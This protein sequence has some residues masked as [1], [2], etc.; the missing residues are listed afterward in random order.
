MAK[1]IAQIQSFNAG[2]DPVRLALKY[3]RMRS[4]AFV[5]LRGSCHLF[6]AALPHEG[7]LAKAP[8][9]W[10]CGD[11][12]LENFGSYKGDNR[13]SYFDLNDFDEAVLAPVSWDLVRLLS[14][15]LVAGPSLHLKAAQAQQLARHG[16]STYTAALAQ[17]HSRWVERATAQGLVGDLLHALGDRKRA[18]FL[19]TRTQGPAAHRRLI[20]DQRKTWPVTDKQ[21]ERVTQLVRKATAPSL[22]PDRAD[23]FKVLDVVGR[24]AGTG[25]LGLARYAVLVQGKG[26]PDGHYLLDLKQSIPS[27]LLPRLKVPQPDWP[28]EGHR[29]VTLQ[30]RM[31]AVSPAFLHAIKDGKRAWQLRALQPTDDRVNLGDKALSLADLA[32]VIEVMAQT[33]AWAHLRSSGRQGSANADELI[34]LAQRPKWPG[35]LIEAAHGM[36]DRVQRDWLTYAQAFDDGALA[37]A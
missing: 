14:S 28:S 1:L 33:T 4:S 16:L 27:S 12:H 35:A 5:F 17:G 29:V 2:R 32:G 20:I 8:L 26:G 19:A 3:Q 9:A 36:A 7:V 34:D 11:L 18:D 13:L 22:D 31:Q 37:L 15:I 23:F 21:R 25:S 24:A 10:V 30:R 6:Y